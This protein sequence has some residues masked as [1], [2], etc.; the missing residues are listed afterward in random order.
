MN[1]LE[2]VVTYGPP[3]ENK[4]MLSSFKNKIFKRSNLSD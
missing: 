4:G 3:K 1:K 2:A